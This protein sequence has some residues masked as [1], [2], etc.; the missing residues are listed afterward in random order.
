MVCIETVNARDHAV[1]LAPGT[2]HHVVARIGVS[3]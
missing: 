3:G 2:S 1:L